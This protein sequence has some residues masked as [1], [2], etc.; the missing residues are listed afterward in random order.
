MLVPVLSAACVFTSLTT[1]AGPWTL[2]AA[3]GDLSVAGDVCV[4]VS[5]DRIAP[6]VT[7]RSF[8]RQLPV[9]VLVF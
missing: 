1:T 9:D 8:E 3:L 6:S 5:T 7:G 2:Q 4:C